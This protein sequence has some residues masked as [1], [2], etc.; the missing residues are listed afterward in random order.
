MKKPQDG[1]FKA[2]KHPET[3]SS[4]PDISRSHPH[5]KTTDPYSSFTSSFIDISTC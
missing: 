1:F 2:G 5:I 3:R 4:S